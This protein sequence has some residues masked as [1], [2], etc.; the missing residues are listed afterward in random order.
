MINKKLIIVLGIFLALSAAGWSAYTNY[1]S[2]GEAE[3]SYN[4]S[5][6]GV[7]SVIYKD[8]LEVDSINNS[9]TLRL[10]K[11]EY[12]LVTSANNDYKE[13]TV[14]FSVSDKPV[15][16]DVN[17]SYSESKLSS[18]LKGQEVNINSVIINNV[19]LNDRFKINPGELYGHGEWYGTTIVPNLSNQELESGYVDVYRIVLKKENDTWQLAMKIPELVVSRVDYPEIPAEVAN[20]VNRQFGEVVTGR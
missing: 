14:N 10:K 15:K 12:K 19:N 4:N 13:Q 7:T 11:G 6:E 3:I 17:P 16:V 20:D 2:Y 9:A 1:R 5:V 18:I 8:D